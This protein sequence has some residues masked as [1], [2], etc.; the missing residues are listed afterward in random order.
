MLPYIYVAH[1]ANVLRIFSHILILDSLILEVKEFHLSKSN[2]MIYLH[3]LNDIL[4]EEELPS[5]ILF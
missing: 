5:V 2:T 3:F 4:V 1:K